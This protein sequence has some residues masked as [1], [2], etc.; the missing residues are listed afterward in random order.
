MCKVDI[1]TK[2]ETISQAKIDAA[3]DV[4]LQLLNR[5][6]QYAE[7]VQADL[8]GG[9]LPEIALDSDEAVISTFKSLATY[10]RTHGVLPLEGLEDQID[11]PVMKKGIQYLADGWEP[12]L[13]RSILE[14]YRDAYLQSVKT[15]LDM[16][17]QGIDSLAAKN[18]P[19]GME[20]ILRGYIQ[21]A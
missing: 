16:I 20:E 10:V 11:H 21:E 17:L 19:E 5:N 12:L 4:F 8:S 18:H 15:R 13:M 2:K 7:G 6:I 1:E 9:T 3:Q 14:K